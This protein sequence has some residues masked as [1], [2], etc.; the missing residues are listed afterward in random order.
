MCTSCVHLVFV[1]WGWIGYSIARQAQCTADIVED[2]RR[3]P[4]AVSHPAMLAP[5]WHADLRLMQSEMV[6]ESWWR[7]HCLYFQ[8]RTFSFQNVTENWLTFW[9][10]YDC[11]LTLPPFS[12]HQECY[13]LDGKVEYFFW[14]IAKD[15]AMCQGAAVWPTTWWGQW[16][17]LRTETLQQ[18]VASI[19]YFLQQ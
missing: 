17:C 16:Q 3:C 2:M 19:L 15:A 13:S 11:F 4:P 10:W 7:L 8:V 9:R 6:L 18:Y 5:W 12:C 14:G 1:S